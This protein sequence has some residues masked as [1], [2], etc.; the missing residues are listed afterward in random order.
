MEQL[1]IQDKISILYC[2]SWHSAKFGEAIL[3]PKV[4]P[5]SIYYYV[6]PV[7]ESVHVNVK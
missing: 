2:I 4:F 6:F 1:N 5:D 3:M 7:L